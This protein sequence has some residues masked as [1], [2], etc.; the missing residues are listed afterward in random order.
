MVGGRKYSHKAKSHKAK[1]HK[2]KSHRKS[3][4]KSKSHRMRKGGDFWSPPLPLPSD[5]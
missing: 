2:A 5:M 1:S 4:R 3:H